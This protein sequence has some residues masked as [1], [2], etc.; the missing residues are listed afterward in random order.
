MDIYAD[1]QIFYNKKLSIPKL[2]LVKNQS[3]PEIYCNLLQQTLRVVAVDFLP[4][5]PLC[6]EPGIFMPGARHLAKLELTLLPL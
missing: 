2:F 1:P 3:I 5:R 4:A 6:D